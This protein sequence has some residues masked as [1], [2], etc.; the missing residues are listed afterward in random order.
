MRNQEVLETRVA[1]EPELQ[2]AYTDL[3]GRGLNREAALL[4]LW[5]NFAN[6]PILS[7]L[8]PKAA[9]FRLARSEETRLSPLSENERVNG[10]ERG[11]FW[12]PIS[13][14]DRS[15][16]NRSVEG[17]GTRL[18]A[19]WTVSNQHVIDWSR[20]SVALLRARAS[21]GS[22]R[23]K[24]YIRNEE[25]WFCEGVAWNKVASYLRC[26]RA[27][28]TGI[29][30][31]G[32]PFIRPIVPW[33]STNVLLALLN[34][35]V[36]DFILRTFLCSRMNVL[37]GDVRGIPLPVLSPEQIDQ[38]STL[39]ESA[40]AEKLRDDSGEPNRL[41]EIEAKV[42]A[43]VRDLYGVPQDAELWVVR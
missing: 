19:K 32:A 33:L 12:I 5:D 40:I 7:R 6:D 41:T 16:E 43:Y 27:E 8:W 37:I 31:D 17:R 26:R 14:G 24:P 4:S 20:E 11:P 3:R 28:A 21:G 39:A 9:T 34:A 23:R 2:A 10:I 29:I 35:P 15:D 30:G 25:L 22:S 1:A 18:G 42:D 36:I 38:L 13:K